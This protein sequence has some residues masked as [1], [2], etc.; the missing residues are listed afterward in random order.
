[1]ANSRR[2][3]LAMCENVE[4]RGGEVNNG[5]GRIN[6]LRESWINACLDKLMD[7]RMSEFEW[8]GW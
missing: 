4:G 3:V 7:V 1:V 2:K 8:M 5:T 6:R